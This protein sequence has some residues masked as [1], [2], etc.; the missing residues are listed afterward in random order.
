LSKA[1]LNLYMRNLC[2]GFCAILLVLFLTTP[3]ASAKA[4]PESFADLVEKL[5]PAVVNISTTQSVKGFGLP[6]SQ[7]IFPPGSPFEGFN[8]LFKDQGPEVE[9]KATSLGSGF[10]ID[11]SGI[12][13]TNG[14]VVADAEEIT[15]TLQDDTIL[16]AE[17]IGRDK[18][19]DIAI[20]RVKTDKQ[21]P[22]VEFGNSDK[23]RVGDWILAIGNPYGLGG[24]VSAGIISARARDINVGLFDDFL[25]TDA[26]IN[27]GNSGGPM[28]DMEGKVV[29]INT[30]I[31]SPSGGNV[32]IGFAIPSALAKPVIDQVIKYGRAKRAW[33]GVKIQGITKEIAESLGMQDDKGALVLGVLPK[34]PAENIGLQEGDVIIKFNG[35]NIE[36]MRKLPRI[37]AETPIG[38]NVA[39]QIY[40]DGAVKNYNIK[41]TEMVDEEEATT[42]PQ[43]AFPHSDVQNESKEVLGMSLVALT[44]D[45][46]AK[47]NIAAESGLLVIDTAKGS[48]AAER[49]IRR[50]QILIKANQK[51][52]LNIADLETAISSAKKD[53]RDSILLLVGAHTESRFIPLPIE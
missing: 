18:K 33:L 23:V 15:V 8:D 46:R 12:I 38:K 6:E 17:I 39:I 45:I 22:F 42:K 7:F 52:L 5:N 28:F 37:V 34:S 40:R 1:K 25:Q 14:H 3:N 26:A 51:K 53:G 41:L 44:K 35:S 13:V 27:R 24:S 29:G 47:Y 36:S 2:T 9:R 4:P 16:Q 19:I 32:G 43:K 48:V 49:G 20:L 11:P 21:L 31:F 50:G 10:I 30:A